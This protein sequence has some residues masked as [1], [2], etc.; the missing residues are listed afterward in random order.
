LIAH[1]DDRARGEGSSKTE[2]AY[3]RLFG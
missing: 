1:F 2:A 3:G